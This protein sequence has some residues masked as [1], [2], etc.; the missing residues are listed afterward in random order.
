M[1]AHFSD[2]SGTP[3]LGPQLL[4]SWLGYR[5]RIERKLAASGFTDRRLPDG[6]ILRLCVANEELTVSRIGREM[7]ISRQGASKLVADLCERG[8]LSLEKSSGDGREKIVR[9]TPD[10]IAFLRAFRE[11]RREVDEEIREHLGD[12]AVRALAALTALLAEPSGEWR[13]GDIWREVRARSSL[14]DLGDM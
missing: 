1:V 4:R 5:R 14:L 11:A 2:E 9:P 12:E 13:T 3:A 7:Q 6:M 8:F 10:A